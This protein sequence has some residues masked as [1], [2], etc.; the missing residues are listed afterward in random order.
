MRKLFQRLLH[1]ILG[2]RGHL[3]RR[4][5]R[6]RAQVRLAQAQSSCRRPRKGSWPVPGKQFAEV[7]GRGRRIVPE[8]SPRC[9]VGSCPVLS[10]WSRGKAEMKPW[11]LYHTASEVTIF[12]RPLT[13]FLVDVQLYFTRAKKHYRGSNHLPRRNCHVCLSQACSRYSGAVG[14]RDG[15]ASQFCLGSLH[16][17]SPASLHQRISPKR[18]IHPAATTIRC[19][20]SR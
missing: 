19:T 4:E 20:N 5:I 15:D 12:L 14:H 6:Q 2:K 1:K 16:G 7:P 3:F 9:C 8:P 17:L 10:E 18:P 13:D 11:R